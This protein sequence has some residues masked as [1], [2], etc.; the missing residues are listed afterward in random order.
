MAMPVSHPVAVMNFK[1][2]LANV[3]VSAMNLMML[4]VF[5][6]GVGSVDL[7]ARD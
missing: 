1:L 4:Y 5:F 7:L 3:F 2:I 6:Y